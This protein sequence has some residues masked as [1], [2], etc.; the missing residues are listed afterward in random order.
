MSHTARTHRRGPRK[1]RESFTVWID[2]I[3]D[4]SQVGP[5]LDFIAGCPSDGG[6]TFVIGPPLSDQ[7]WTFDGTP[8]IEAESAAEKCY[9]RLKAACRA[10]W[11][12]YIRL[13]LLHDDK[14]DRCEKPFVQVGPAKH[15]PKSQGGGHEYAVRRG[16]GPLVLRKYQRGKLPQM[17]I[18]KMRTRKKG[19]A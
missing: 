12:P 18:R 3:G 14:P 5:L 19:A 13:R 9:D 7:S 16:R 10:R 6:G 11:S 1:W 17:P 4:R 15:F 8:I 2:F